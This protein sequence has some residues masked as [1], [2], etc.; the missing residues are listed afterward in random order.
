MSMATWLKDRKLGGPENVTVFTPAPMIAEDA[1]EDV[2][3]QL[4]TLA[5][6]MGFNYW[7]NTQD[8]TRLTADAIEFADGRTLPAEVKIIFP[9]W[10]AHDFVKGLSLIHI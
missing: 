8:I 3:K 2:V 10:V 1:G 9:D 6:K 4:L 7:N 5:T